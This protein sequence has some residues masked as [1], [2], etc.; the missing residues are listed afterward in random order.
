ME[1]SASYV[2]GITEGRS[3]LTSMGGRDKVTIKEMQEIIT[4][5]KST[6]GQGFTGDVAAMLRGERD[7]WINQ[8]SIKQGLKL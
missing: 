2:I 4:N 3:L 5:L 8:L 7:F 1:T 6:L